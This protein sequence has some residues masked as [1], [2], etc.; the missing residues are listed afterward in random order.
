VFTQSNATGEILPDK[1]ETRFLN[2]IIRLLVIA[3]NL[4]A[5][6]GARDELNQISKFHKNAD[7]IA[8]F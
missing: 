1:P 3:R 5:L 7:P 4:V 2:K 6:P 8:I